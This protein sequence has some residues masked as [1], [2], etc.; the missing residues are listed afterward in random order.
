MG[1]ETDLAKLWHFYLQL[2]TVEE[3]FKNLKKN[4][5]RDLAIWSNIPATRSAHR[6][7]YLHRLPRLL[8]ARHG[9]PTIVPSGAGIDSA[10]CAEKS[11]A[12]KM[13]E[14][15]TDGRELVTRYT[16]PRVPP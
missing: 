9:E 2:V 10:Q 13:L 11:A 1:G 7:T 12:V 6:G 5:K 4:L 16:Q 14:P 15:T 3:D 8:P